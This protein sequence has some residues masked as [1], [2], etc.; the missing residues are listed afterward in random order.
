M[1]NIAR[2]YRRIRRD[3]MVGSSLAT[4]GAD[5]RVVPPDHTRTLGMDIRALKSAIAVVL[6]AA[7]LVA[8]PVG[9]GAA[10]DATVVAQEIPE[11][12][13]AVRW[14]FSS[15]SPWNMPIGSEAKYSRASD[16]QTLNLIDPS[17][18]AWVNA[19][20]YSHPTYIARKSD[21]V[22]DV[23]FKV[24]PTGLDG[25]GPAMYDGV[26]QYRIPKAAEP[27]VGEDGH[28]HVIDPDRRSLHETWIFSWDNGKPT[29]AG[30][31]LT[32]LYGTG[33]GSVDGVNAG[34]RAYGGSAIGGLI[35]TWE[36]KSREI[37]HVLA[38]ALTS[39]QLKEGWVWPATEEDTGSDTYAGRIP[40]G[41][42]VAIPPSVDL[43][44]LGLSKD[45]RVLAKALQDYGAYVTDRS[46]G[47]AFYAEP[48][49]ERRLGSMR[50][51]LDKIRAQLR[52]VTN[53]GPSSVGGGG[54]PRVPLAPPLADP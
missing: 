24:A 32:D 6:S 1:R 28:L 29:A 25:S 10:G 22:Y 4:S 14:P 42:L 17:V 44:T 18:V 49:A 19:K 33:M 45:G 8:W 41:S 50:A 51:D 27:A 5:D 11:T 31:A 48:S 16:P 2:S 26:V 30:Y 54:E 9:A 37:Q 52:I 34:M 15:T 7:T 13:N 35:R 39:K 46:A 38:I 12:R 36:L 20:E 3:P 23:H 53:N 21:P 47:F 43:S 40:M